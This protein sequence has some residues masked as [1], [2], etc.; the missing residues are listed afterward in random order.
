M[1]PPAATFRMSHTWRSCM[2]CSLHAEG[3]SSSHAV[4]RRARSAGQHRARDETIG[5][6]SAL[7]RLRSIGADFE[8]ARI[9]LDFALLARADHPLTRCTADEAHP[10]LE[11]AGARPYV[12]RLDAAMA[13]QGTA[14][15]RTHA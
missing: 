14:L 5:R 10:I 1:T 7:S 12:A 9:S 8:I 3:A 4:G 2:G 13:G 6:R 11:R 15:P